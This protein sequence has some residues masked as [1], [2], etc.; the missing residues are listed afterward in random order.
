[1]LTQGGFNPD[2]R[3][4]YGW[5]TLAAASAEP[6]AT[7]VLEQN[8]K[9]VERSSN[10]VTT[11]A[12]MRRFPNT[13]SHQITSNMYTTCK[14]LSDK[15]GLEFTSLACSSKDADSTSPTVPHRR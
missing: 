15:I 7:F 8:P 10:P 3:I 11:T 6:N 2:D 4:A 1:M 9:L 5:Y 13:Q 12:A 14:R